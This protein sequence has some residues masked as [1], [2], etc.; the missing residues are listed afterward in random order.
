MKYDYLNKPSP[1]RI[2]F[3]CPKC[4]LRPVNSLSFKLILSEY[5][6]HGIENINCTCHNCGLRERLLLFLEFH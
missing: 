5:Q 6:I 2:S 3:V 1:Q 4:H